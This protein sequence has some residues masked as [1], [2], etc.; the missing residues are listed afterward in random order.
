MVQ[1][2]G[3]AVTCRKCGRRY[4]LNSRLRAV[5]PDVDAVMADIEHEIDGCP[6]CT[7]PDDGG[8]E[9]VAAE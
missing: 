6:A 2:G 8:G 3:V 5:D 1:L 9:T 7:G 4:D